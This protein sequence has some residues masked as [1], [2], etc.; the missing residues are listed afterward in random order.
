[1][2][3]GMWSWAIRTRCEKRGGYFTIG[4]DVIGADVPVT[5][6]LSLGWL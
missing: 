3:T 2:D 6:A 1:M 5:T 4:A